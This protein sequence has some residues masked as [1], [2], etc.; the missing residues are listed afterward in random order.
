[1]R[2]F[3]NESVNFWKDSVKRYKNYF[4]KE[5]VERQR[6]AFGKIVQRDTEL[7]VDKSLSRNTGQFLERMCQR[8]QN[9]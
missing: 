9:S 4:V 2:Y 3:D 7:M 6:T 1:M 5:S 8:V